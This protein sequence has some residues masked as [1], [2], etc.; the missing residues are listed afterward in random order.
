MLV[1]GT[2]AAAGI[3]AAPSAA[4]SPALTTPVAAGGQKAPAE[5]LT[6]QQAAHQAMASGKSVVAS[7]LTTADSLTT[8][9]PN[10]TLTLT[11]S[12]VP[13]RVFQSGG[14][15]N[16]DPSLK[17]NAN[18]T[19][20]PRAASDS[21]FLS[22][23]GSGPVASL[24]TGGQGFS[25]TLP[26]AL[27]HPTVSGSSADYT[28]VIPGVDLAVT[29]LDDGAVS[30]VFT[31]RTK[32][33]AQD[34][35]LAT[36]LDATATT[37]PGLHTVTD[38]NSDLSIADSHGHQF[39]SAP[40]PQAWDSNSTSV[41][42][43]VARSSAAARLSSGTAGPGHGAHAVKLAVAAR[44]GKIDLGLPTA[45]LSAPGT[46]YPVYLDPT[47]SPDWGNTGWASTGSGVPSENYWDSTVDSVDTPLRSEVG[48]SGSVQAEA[49]S[50]FNFPIN[51]STLGDAKIY[52]ASFGIT[53]TY[54]WA[55]LT[56]GHD[57]TVDLYAPSQVL[58][59]SNANWNAWS[60]SLG[61]S[62]AS[63]SFALG[64]NSSC[65]TGPTPAFSST[66]LTTDITNDIA[67]GRTT[68]TLVMR[69]DDHSDNYAF[70]KFDPK[71]AQL[72]V[73][74]DKYPS[75]PNGLKTS[76]ATNCSSETLG[77]TSV[78][79]YATASTPTKSSLTTSFSLYK[80]SDSTKTDLLTTANGVAS[81]TWTGAS[82]QAAVLALPESFFAKQAGGADTAF[83][84]IAVTGDGT[85]SSGW[86]S[87]CTF[88]WDP[89]RPGAPGVAPNP[90][91]TGGARTC[92]TRDQPTAGTV[93]SIGATCSFT[94]TQPTTN[95][96]VTAVSG[97][98]YQVNQSPP[99]SV[100]A[101][102]SVTISVPVDRLVNTLT[103]NALSAGGNIGSATPVWFDGNA[104]SPAAKDGDLTLDGNPDLIVPGGS[105]SAYPPGLW[106]ADGRPDGT[107]ATNATN[108]GVN[109]LGFNSTATPDDWNGA[110]AITGDF[111][112]NGAQDVM[113][114]FAGT[115]NGGGGSVVCNDGGGG[116]DTSSAPYQVSAGSLVDDN[117]DDVTQIANGGNTSGLGTGLPDLLATAPDGNLYLFYAPT[118]NAYGN[119]YGCQGGCYELSGLKSP[120]GNQDWN[121]WTIASAQLSTGT[122]L[123]LWNSGSGVL[124]LWTGLTLDSTRTTLDAANQYTVATGWMTNKSLLLRAA[125]INGSGIPD[126]WA[127]DPATGTTTTYM[128]TT[129][130]SSPT[131]TTTS[132]TTSTDSHSWP[133][134]DIGTAGSGSAVSTT[135]DVTGNPALTLTSSG[136][137]ATWDTGDADFPADISLNGTSSGVLTSAAA[138]N[139]DSSFSVSAWV[140]PAAVG[141]VVLAQAGTYGSGFIL[142]PSSTGWQFCMETEDVSGYAYDCAEGS[143]VTLNTWVHLTATFNS[144]SKTMTLYQDGQ[145]VG[146]AT[147]T[148]VIGYTNK[149][150][151]GDQ[152]YRGALGGYFTGDVAGIETWT[153]ALTQ[154]QEAT[155][156]GISGHIPATVGQWDLTDGTG[157]TAADFSG[158]NHP[159]TLAGGAS[160]Y[161][162]PTYPGETLSLNGTSGYAQ[163]SGSVV[164]TSKSLTASVWVR[165]NGDSANSTFVSESD[166]AGNENGFQLYYSATA[167]AWGFD[168]GDD[169]TTTAAFSPIYGPTSGPGSAQLGTWTLL[170]GVFNAGSNLMQ[171][172]VDGTLVNSGQYTGSVW[173]AG[174]DIQ[175]GRRLYQRAYAE[176]ADADLSQVCVWN[177]ALTSGQISALYQQGT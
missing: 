93:P 146:T 62:V 4:A 79:L 23:G 26:I 158:G 13:V 153:T 121:N 25:L 112:G 6:T 60:G 152:M 18:G 43:A 17:T 166:T 91:P 29:V 37:T 169:D 85:L 84:F 140:K 137:G 3:S 128:P 42:T 147:H 31:V 1:A 162:D 171:L 66:T 164:D 139:V 16:L 63:N 173:N 118:T 141:G 40:T 177:T 133:L 165:L 51:L 74:Y 96:T 106:L 124:D 157:T 129:L 38:R 104:I 19:L 172:Y 48:N 144:T 44:G 65:P 168:R 20:S 30:D 117:G 136:S 5:P 81:R 73:T 176:Y 148:P 64:Y 87:P 36:L 92:D 127:T 86:S 100:T 109:G 111:C 77:D 10:G 95:G 94:L 55:C 32:A 138:V 101:T 98:L 143:A 27:P 123:Y 134:D 167:G 83:A 156:G 108:I 80:T 24:Y 76:P 126:L 72:T 50:L 14:W 89:T 130:T 154:Q 102:G 159:A 88:H 115:T 56:S 174:G 2:L 22:G 61:S 135:G 103:V 49:M 59:S 33:A 53:E 39:F 131:L 105:G 28:D 99:V 132:T 54:S 67:A 41:S 11:Q 52:G 90:S 75:T 45:L 71:T 46:I 151:V 21:V 82:G 114:Y 161:L 58:T 9:N 160:W 70:K 69:A 175:L 122:A 113:A 78:T 149:F 97:Y 116:L 34:P 68:Q 155:Q 107:V 170:T 8:A 12:A 150:Q 120:D 57:Q 7:A 47:Y 145:P 125:D 163:T 119:S 142:Y 35:R 110:Q 15:V